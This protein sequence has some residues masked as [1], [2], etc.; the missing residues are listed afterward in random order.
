MLDVV[1][2]QDHD[3]PVRRQVAP[4]QALADPAREAQRLTVGDAAPA[5]RG[6]AL[7]EQDAIGG[8]LGPEFEPAAQL[9]RVIAERV[10]R[11][12]HDGA[13]GAALDD[14]IGGAQSYL[15]DRRPLWRCVKHR[16]ASMEL[17]PL[18]SEQPPSLSGRNA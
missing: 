15:A 14:Y 16:G 4:Q 8:T 7:R 12:H 9:V 17:H 6:R 13:V 2:G 11:A 5:A 10:R 1:A 18:T 3:R